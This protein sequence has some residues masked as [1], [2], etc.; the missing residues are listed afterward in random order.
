MRVFAKLCFASL[1]TLACGAVLAAGGEIGAIVL[2]GKWGSPQS[3][4][5]GLTAA[6]GREHIVV[7][8]PEMPWSWAR[9]YDKGMEAADAEIDAEIARLRAGGAKHIFLI[10]HSMGANYVLHYSARVPVT[11]IVAIAPGHR[12]E[13]RF[14]VQVVGADVEKARAMVVAG[15][16]AETLS[17][18]DLNSGN[19]QQL[20]TA[21]AASFLTYFDAA[22][23]LNMTRNARSM[24]PDI[25]TLWIVP[26]REDPRARPFVA[27]LYRSLP[28]NRGTRMAEPDADHMSAPG[29][30]IQIVVD[31]IR[32]IVAK[33]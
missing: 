17:F 7:S 9:Q 26:K 11:G 28:Q 15:K 23:P 16:G 31:W 12:P 20:M 2:H 6:L 13:S 29:A 4:V 21:S 25:P 33:K 1:A 27:E 30:S 19:R 5:D 3:V 32:A 22:G 24:R 10:G 8:A 14:F 18:V